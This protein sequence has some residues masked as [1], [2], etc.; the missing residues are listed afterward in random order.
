MQLKN[1][2][3]TYKNKSGIVKALDDISLDIRYNGLYVIY[4]A[5]G[6]GK[7]TLLNIIARNDK[8]YEGKYINTG[9]V[10][11]LRQEGGLIEDL[12]VLDNLLLCSKDKKRIDDLLDDLAIKDIRHK[13]IRQLSSGQKKRVQ[14]LS[15]I[16]LKPNVLLLD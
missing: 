16:L 5:S 6:S 2:S 1:I 14:L 10:S 9:T 11:Y 15:A 3:K 4:G 8:D 12:T 7:S 13:K